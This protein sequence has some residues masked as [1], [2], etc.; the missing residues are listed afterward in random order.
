LK[1]IAF[2]SL[3]TGIYGYGRLTIHLNDRYPIR[4]A[5]QVAAE[6]IRKWLD[7]PVSPEASSLPNS[8]IVCSCCRVWAD[9]QMERVI[10]CVFSGRDEEVYNDIVPNYFP[11]TAE[12]LGAEK[13]QEEDPDSGLPE[14]TDRRGR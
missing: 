10:F 9:H 6:T 14:A 13:E 7:S 12:D 3:S 8:S 2:P 11:P 5:T 4:E 1:N